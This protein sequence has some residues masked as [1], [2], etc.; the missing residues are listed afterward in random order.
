MA[1]RLAMLA[2]CAIFT[3]GAMAQESVPA[4]PPVV[5]SGSPGDPTAPTTILTQPSGTMSK[6]EIKDQ[7]K[8]QKRDEAAAR[9]NAKAAKASASLLNADAK[10]KDAND[11]ALQAQ[12]KAGQ[13][14]A[15][16]AAPAVPEAT[17]VPATAAPDTKAPPQ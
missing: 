1:T 6:G 5:M 16:P 7:R 14:T 13:V 9:A 4:T 11:K 3:G 15:V 2:L 8:Q 17:P 10:S 12:E